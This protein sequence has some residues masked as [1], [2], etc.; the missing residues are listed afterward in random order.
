MVQYNESIHFDR[1]L[2][3]QDITGS[4]AF[5]RA[6]AKAGII[7]QDEFNKLEQGLLAVKKEWEDGTFK[8][9]PGVDEDIP[10]LGPHDCLQPRALPGAH[11]VLLDDMVAR[12]GFEACDGCRAPGASAPHRLTKP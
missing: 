11:A 4:I 12:V 3:A 9:V 5:A 2:F 1:A 8:I 6:N 7:T 10:P